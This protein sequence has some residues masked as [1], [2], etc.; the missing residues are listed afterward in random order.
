[1]KH[2]LNRREFLITSLY[3]AAGITLGLKRTLNAEST[4]KHTLRKALIVDKPSE[5]ILKK[6]KDAGFEGLEAG[7]VSRTEAEKARQIAERLGLRIHSVIRGWAQFNSSNKAELEK[8]FDVTI[9]ALV[10][11]KGYG[12]DTI[13][14]APGAIDPPAVPRPSEFQ[15]K[16]D[17]T[18]GH[19]ITVAEKDNE[20]YHD[21]I[22]AHNHAFETFQSAIRKLIPM[23]EKTGVVIAIE[24]VWNNLFVD[25]H[26]MAYF[27]D[28]F[29]SPWV[30][31]YFDI[32][33][34]VK[35]SLP[36][37]WIAIL[38]KRIVKCHVKD[39]KLNSNGH[40]GS[41]VNIRQGSVN[42]PG[43]CKALETIG[44]NGWMTIE[45]SEELSLEEQNR[46]LDLIIA[47][48]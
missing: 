25:P 31:S 26:H 16:F 39:F 35:Y 33:N 13:L 47:G 1:M 12:A 8:S 9:D 22:S 11:A 5:E 38:G 6:I 43:V 28:S 7:V 42:W 3:T 19:V 37:Q 14:L 36:E 17:R 10:A 48:K 30:R 44:Y 4:F 23:S 34:H 24:N 21:Y 29:N 41:F 20:N 27:I 46:R 2:Y 18:T 15:I 45:G 40:G 32:G